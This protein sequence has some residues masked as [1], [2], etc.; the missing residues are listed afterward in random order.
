MEEAMVAAM[1]VLLEKMH[2]HLDGGGDYCFLE[3]IWRR[4]WI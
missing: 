3:S 2:W 1:H 4:R